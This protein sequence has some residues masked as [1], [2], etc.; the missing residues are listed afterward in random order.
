VTGLTNG[1]EYAIEVRAVNGVGDGIISITLRAMSKTIPSAPA[2]LTA[3]YGNEQVILSWTTPYD[4][5]NAIIKYQ[6]SYGPAEGY[7]VNW[8]DI[9]GSDADTVTYTVT[10]LINK[11]VYTFEIRAVN[12]VGDSDSSGTADARPFMEDG[13]APML[14][15]VFVTLFAILGAGYFVQVRRP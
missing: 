14:A 3:A 7:Q 11:T 15:A 13:S 8:I 2:D 4:G 5:G 1:V 12:A 10:G 9:P 6:I